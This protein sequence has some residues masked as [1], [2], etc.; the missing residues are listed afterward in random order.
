M[1]GSTAVVMLKSADVAKIAERSLIK[2]PS[3]PPKILNASV[4]TVKPWNIF[5]SPNP[6]QPAP[7]AIC[8][9]FTAPEIFHGAKSVYRGCI[10]VVQFV[11]WVE[12]G[13]V[14]DLPD[15]PGLEEEGSGASE[16]PAM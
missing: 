1:N 4:M 7:Q 9:I 14:Q 3:E 12:S 13:H 11:N 5:G 2:A 8:N 16:L 6:D 10:T 15:M